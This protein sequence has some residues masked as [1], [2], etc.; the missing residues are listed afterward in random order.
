M[1]EKEIKQINIFDNRITESMITIHTTALAL[2]CLAFGI[3]NCVV[4]WVIPGI[5]II[6][7]GVLVSVVVRLLK[8]RISKIHRGTILSA[9][10]L[11]LIL[12]MSVLKH[13][14]HTMFPLL[15]AGLILSSVYF[16]RR[17]VTYQWVLINIVCIIGFIFMR[18]FFYA[19]G[20][21]E[22]ILKGFLGFNI[23]AVLLAY[24]VDCATQFMLS[25]FKSQTT[26]EGLLEQV[27]SE[28]DKTSRLMEHQTSV[29]SKIEHISENLNGSA[30]FMEQISTTLSAGAQEQESTIS[31]IS[32]DIAGIVDKVK[33][34][35][36]EAEK[37][38]HSAIE[39]TEKLHDNNDEV[40]HMLE[41]MEKITT[42]SQEIETIIR[43]I[44]DIAFQTNI[45]ALNAAVEAARAGNA[46][47]GFAVVA[48][49]VRN[50]AT[51]SSEAAKNTSVL[52]ETTITAVNNGTE[53]AGRVAER[54]NEA[55]RISEQSSAHS[56]RIADITEDQVKSINEIRNKIDSISYVVSQT[57]QTSEKSAEIARSVS[58][59]VQ[60]MSKIV[61]EYRK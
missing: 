7:S 10:Q 48:D 41:A 20:S 54:M 58:G 47:K 39:S 23:G 50:L 21:T 52:I 14:L 35:L 57:S 60:E 1:Q 33:E 2:S 27:N 43:T 24:V 13:E 34:G 37:A 3:V 49:E 61:K 12:V 8:D 15:V 25:S 42:A 29:V 36:D 59:E 16:N 11:T 46:G 9:L 17:M 53:L 44:E 22:V 28:M 18:S 6:A 30:S 55:I 4:G 5:V 31:E 38:S 56:R 32:S 45:L 40:Q 26:A 51:K 19:D